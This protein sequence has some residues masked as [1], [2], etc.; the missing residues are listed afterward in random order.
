MNLSKKNI[1]QWLKKPPANKSIINQGDTTPFYSQ[2]E[3]FKHYIEKFHGEVE[4]GSLLSDL[5]KQAEAGE[6][7]NYDAITLLNDHGPKH[8]TTVIERVTQLLNVNSIEFNVREIFILLNAIQL[9]DVGNFYG[10]TGHEQR[11]KDIFKDGLPLIAF[12]SVEHNYIKNVAQVHGGYVIDNDGSKNKN[13]IGSIKPDV[14]SDG[15]VI[16]QRLLA[17]LLRF[18]DE[19]ADDKHRAAINLLKQEGLPKGSEVFHAYSAC[20][21]TVLVKHETKTVELHFKIPK[22]FA[23][24]KFGKIN[25]LT[26][27]VEEVYLIDEIY[28]RAIKMHE[29]R[30]YCSKFWK[31]KIELDKIWVQIEFYHLTE[32]GGHVH[33]DITFSIEDNYYPNQSDI[34]IFKLCPNLVI[35]G[36]P[37]DGAKVEMN[38]NG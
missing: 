21:D 22:E 34:D 33:H 23:I 24:K 5:K 31:N 37:L 32:I 2:Y 17:S 11:I 3:S 18:A 16:R 9:H 26:D 38:I 14:T 29:E 20:L 15:Y 7:V 30:N 1:E 12:D 36:N 6:A 10:R 19:I 25:K 13:T 8:I 27:V 28:T 4:R 35:E